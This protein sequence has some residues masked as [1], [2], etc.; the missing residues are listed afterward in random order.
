MAFNSLHYAIFLPCV[1]LLY[2][3]LPQRLR[4][5][6]LL[7]ASY[8]FYMSW[9][10]NLVVLILFTTCTSYFSARAISRAGDNKRRKRGILA[11]GVSA[12]L[13][14]LFFFKYFNFFS[15]AVTDL[16]RAFSLPVDG[17]VL[18]LILPIGISFYTF[19]TLSYVIDVY[20]GKMPVEKHFGI[21]A[22]YVSFFPQL[23]AGP[24][25]RATNLLPQ[26]YEKHT[27]S[28]TQLSE[29]LRKIL[30]GLFKKVVIADFVAGYVNTVYNDVHAF[31]GLSII[32]ATLLFAVQIYC[33]FSGY[34]DIAVGSARILGFRLMENFISPYF[35]RSIKEF[36]RRWHISLS[37]WFSD[38]VYIPLGGNRVKRPRHLFNILVTFLL[39]GLWHG[40]N[41]T[42][43]LW[44][45]LHGVA[46]V[47][48]VFLLPRREKRLARSTAGW[49]RG[50]LSV[51]WWLLTMAV[52]MLG[53]VLFRAN[54]LADAT[55]LL[56]HLFQGL[57]PLRLMEYLAPM[58]IDAK[59]L[60]AILCLVAVLAVWDWAN[61]RDSALRRFE[62]F[63]PAV[64]YLL[65][66]AVGFVL[67]LRIFTTAGN[68][69]A[70]FIYFQ[71]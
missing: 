14:C 20:R 45:L 40:A 21:Y 1:I 42:F 65:Y 64:R 62:K 58:G 56:T 46:L 9:N 47:A 10:P 60:V 19:Q 25:E 38:Y 52:V 27:F 31:S 28:A 18:Q 3:V 49:Q 50:L 36:W 16:L 67:L 37:T 61:R 22:L 8:Y 15:Q 17:V 35:S 44:G 48:E 33:D 55:Y 53:W 54:S 23:V 4:W 66:Y 51:W 30:L 63:R 59:T 13:L 69:S 5:V 39:S 71:F 43:L 57:N 2:F 41:W 24:I 29:G 68:V 12:S 70:D 34:S 6:L 11:V 32:A 7:A 26:F